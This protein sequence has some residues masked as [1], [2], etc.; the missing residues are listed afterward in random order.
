MENLIKVNFRRKSFALIA[1]VLMMTS[2]LLMSAAFTA[3]ASAADVIPGS[4]M[5]GATSGVVGDLSSGANPSVTMDTAAFL[6]VSP[7]PIGIGQ[8]AL[9]NMW[10]T[11]PISPNRFQSGYYV[12]I[13]RP[14]GTT[15][16]VGPMDSYPADATAWFQLTPDQTGTYQFKFRFTGEYWPN[17]TY[18]IGR[19]VPAGSSSAAYYLDTAYYKPA[20]TNWQNLT[21]QSNLVSSWP[22]A[23]LPT[24]YW[25]RPA[26]V[27]NREWWSILGN[28]PPYGIVGGGSSWPADT[29]TYITHSNFVPYVQGPNTCHVEYK[30]QMSD[31]GI[32][33][34]SAGSYSLGGGAGTPS[35]IYNGRCYQTMTVPINGVPTSCAVCWDLQTG[36]QYYAI[37]T[38]SSTP[39]ALGGITPN[40]ISYV[41]PGTS[42]AA[43]AGEVG[44]EASGTY[45]VS[46]IS[47]AGDG[48]FYKIN[49]WTGAVT[50]NMSST[51]YKALSPQLMGGIQGSNAYTGFYK[52]PYVL[53]V[54][55][56]TTAGVSKYYLINWTTAGT[57][58]NFTQR[59]M[60]NV[61]LPFAVPTYPG[62]ILGYNTFVIDPET[63]IMI[64][65]AGLAPL[66]V[67]VY[68]GTWMMA[69][70]M[71]T[72]S[73]LWNRT[74]TDMTRYSTACFGADHGIAICLMEGGYYAGFSERNGDLVW[75]TQLMDYPW[76]S[77]SF[78]G[79]QYISA[80]GMFYRCS[81][82]GIYAFNWTNGNIVWHYVDQAV[83][84]ET[85]Y[86]DVNGSQCYSF[87]GGGFAA[88]G[89]LYTY[90]TEHTPTYPITRGWGLMALNIT[91]G[92]R[93]WRIEFSGS[94][95]E[96]SDGYL[97]AGNG[98]DGKMYV[99]GKGESS[100]TLSAPQIAAQTGQSVI[101]T[102]T[103]LD[104]SPA[105]PGTACVSASSMTTWM[106]YL[107]MQQPIDG[108]W[109]NETIAG[110]PVSLDAVDPNGNF[111]HISAVTTDGT[112]G[113]YGYTWTPTIAGDYKI[114]ATFAGDDSYGSS[115]ATTYATA[116]NAPT[117]T[118]PTTTSA[119]S[120]L[121]TTSDLMTYIV[122]VGIAIILA[123]AIA[124]V[125]ILRKR[126]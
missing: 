77:D 44:A 94:P 120:N 102:G 88:D 45:S 34:G 55:T 61:S 72:G 65:M 60:G 121:A 40:I 115:F 43:V 68:H 41:P 96:V 31:A 116:V 54:Q 33:G 28:Y 30:Q 23:A 7:S 36:K 123:V 58:T 39:G 100:T 16:T 70:D 49:P 15:E 22:I 83:P 105:Q 21:V 38:T 101:L 79:Y 47:I 35:V 95:G 117:T 37:P 10:T 73:L 122:A 8:T 48:S 46:L 11:P 85:P 106:Q 5:Q 67:G 26:N 4:P 78:G 76:G 93:V 32:I 90:N 52:D 107:H 14:D 1:I 51:G 99:F 66:G 59:I 9:V 62:G 53:S 109:H 125:L 69:V 19:L 3:K 104:Q 27:M 108:I 25:T 87:N 80:Y 13:I 98:Y 119:P 42:G 24:G 50:F 103:V 86:T 6:S 20:S 75:K 118:T 82:D 91:N 97:V 92:E 84:F 64:W 113:T 81:Y 114:F 112:T 110:V 124:T 126:P 12:D 111:V 74:Y 71:T 17:G 18:L 56:I 63:N 2:A 29:N 89:K 57:T